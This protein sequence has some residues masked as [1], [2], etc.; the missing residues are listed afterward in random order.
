M[1]EDEITKIVAAGDALNEATHR[2]DVAESDANLLYQRYH[3]ARG[4]LRNA[5]AK[6][7][8][9][10]AACEDA[11]KLNDHDKTERSVGMARL[12]VTVL[13]HIHTTKKAGRR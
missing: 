12:A 7:A 4:E 8:A 10:Q 1:V 2:A 5:E 6:L 13:H 11:L 3:Y 9:I